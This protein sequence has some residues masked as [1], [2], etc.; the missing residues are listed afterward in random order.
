M[1][2]KADSERKREPRENEGRP[3]KYKP[4]YCQKVIE[5]GKQGY[6]MAEMASELGVDKAS[7][8]KDWPL[9]HPEFSTALKEAR[10]HSEAWWAGVARKGIENQKVNTPLWSRVMASQFGWSDKIQLDQQIQSHNVNLNKD[11]SQLSPEELDAYWRKAL[12][13]E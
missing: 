6:S 4:E 10:C 5:F 2:K 1:A 3:T 8:I 13:P 7:V 11:V 12:K 9:A